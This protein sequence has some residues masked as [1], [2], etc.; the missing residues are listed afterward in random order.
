MRTARRFPLLQR[1]RYVSKH[2]WG[3]RTLLP[4][5]SAADPS[6]ATSSSSPSPT[7]RCGAAMQDD[8][9]PFFHGFCLVFSKPTLPCPAIHV[10]FFPVF[11]SLPP[12]HQFAALTS[13]PPPPTHTLFAILNN[14][15]ISMFLRFPPDGTFIKCGNIYQFVFVPCTSVGIFAQSFTSVPCICREC[16]FSCLFPVKAL[17][18]PGRARGFV[19]GI[20]HLCALRAIQTF[21]IFF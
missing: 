16:P 12:L 15:G 9:S 11:L 6:R 7:M 21:R 1:Q 3:W 5:S 13:Y 17:V 2:R 14:C 20:P 10:Y 4:R 8:P 18:R 19:R